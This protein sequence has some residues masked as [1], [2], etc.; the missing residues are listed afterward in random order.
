MTGAGRVRSMGS[1]PARPYVGDQ[2]IVLPKNGQNFE[3]SF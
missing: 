3:G 2:R 1:D